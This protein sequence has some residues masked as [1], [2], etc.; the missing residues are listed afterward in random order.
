MSTDAEVWQGDCLERM[1]KVAD[2]SVDAVVTDPPFGIGFRY[3]DGREVANNPRDYWEWLRPRYLEAV[4][5]L[6]PGGF[7][8]VW[9]AQL[10]FRH[11]WDWFG[12]DIH[13]YCAAKN[14][15]QIRSIPINYGYDPV[16]MFYKPGPKPLVPAKQSRS[17]DFFVANTAGIISNMGRIDKEHPCPRPLDQVVQI[18]DNFVVPGGSV[19]DPFAGSGTIGVGCV[20]TGRRFIGIE[21]EP[22][23]CRVAELRIADAERRLDRPHAPLL[24]R[25]VPTATP[26]FDAIGEGVV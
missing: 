26:L 2:E 15:V 10:N 24:R 20:G 3:G 6:K 23:M 9:Q 17:V 1:R 8:A 11:F 5:C 7:V 21:I 13:I 4:R 12:D 22:E 16:V 18:L 14:F 25:F 19:L